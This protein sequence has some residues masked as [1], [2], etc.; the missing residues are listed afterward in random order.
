M[1]NL[2]HNVLGFGYEYYSDIEHFFHSNVPS[3]V[4]VHS[5]VP[6]CSF[7]CVFLAFGFL[8]WPTRP[9]IGVSSM[10]INVMIITTCI[11]DCRQAHS[12][13]QA[14]AIIN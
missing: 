6:L 12:F 4:V 11:K 8:R 14:G 2:I 5:S 1:N 10:G 13:Y 3:S 9:A 7:K